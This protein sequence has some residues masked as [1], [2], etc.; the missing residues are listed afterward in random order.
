MDFFLDIW[1]E[2]NIE[3]I[4]IWLFVYRPIDLKRSKN[5]D[6]DGCDHQDHQERSQ[7]PKDKLNNLFH[8]ILI[9][10]RI[11]EKKN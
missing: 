10:K 8:P 9:S 11:E 2:K 6:F 7:L 1:E 4:S 3:C 5:K